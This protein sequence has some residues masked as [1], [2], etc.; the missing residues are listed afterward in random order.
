MKNSDKGLHHITIIAG[1]PQRNVDFYV[2]KLGLRLVL[3]SVNQDDPGTYHFFYA[4]GSGKPGSSITFFPFKMASATEAGTGEAVAI[5]FSVPTTSRKYWKK[6]LNEEGITYGEI[7]QRF[8][9]DVL[10]FKDPDGLQLELVFDESIN[11]IVAWDDSP[12]PAEFGIRGFWSST[13]L[14]EET[15][16]TARILEEVMGFE[17]TEENGSQTL[18]R[19]GSEIG[20][21]M[22][23]EKAE[24]ANPSRPGK[25]TVHH[26]AFRA[27][28]ADELLEMRS[29]VIKLGLQ[30]T[31]VID[32]HVFRSVYFQT[33]SGVLF[34]IASD[35]PGYAS[36][37]ENEAD[38]GKDL[39]LPPWLEGDRKQIEEHLEPVTA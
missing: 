6:R 14:L 3:K 20:N 9:Y 5:G 22:I 27:K 31:N 21:A 2:K 13:L 15:E 29:K 10:P 33:P 36:V 30:P 1:P 11:E 34:E 38:M 35:D 24:K 7:Y 25:G 32:R 12:V 39:F 23:L 26:V 16:S 18:Y 4:N 8:G 19:T 28:N 17:K 37:V